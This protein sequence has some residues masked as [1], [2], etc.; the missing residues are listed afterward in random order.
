M[1]LGRRF[2]IGAFRRSNWRARFWAAWLGLALMASTG[3]VMGSWT[4][5]AASS[6]LLALWCAQLTR[7]A[8]RMRRRGQSSAI[9]LAYALFIMIS[10]WTQTI[11]QVLY[12]LDWLQRRPPR[13]VEYKG[14][15]TGT[16]RP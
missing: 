14:A 10:F 5:A 3:A 6:A 8:V 13:L 15:A 11:G 4:A 12:G 7:I 9:S 2:G 1:T 16:G